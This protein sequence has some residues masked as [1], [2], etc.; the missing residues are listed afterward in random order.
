VPETPLRVY[1]L[2][3]VVNPHGISVINGATLVVSRQ[4]LS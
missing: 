1:P 2:S 3:T 4:M